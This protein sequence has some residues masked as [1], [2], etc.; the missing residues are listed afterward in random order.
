MHGQPFS[1]R[2][3]LFG[4]LDAEATKKRHTITITI[5]MPMDTTTR[6]LR[7]EAPMLPL[8]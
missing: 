7:G 4:S 3:V 5:T 6:T 2:A 8:P 1:Q